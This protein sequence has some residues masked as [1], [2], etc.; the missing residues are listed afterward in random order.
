MQRRDVIAEAHAALA[1]RGNALRPP[2]ALVVDA[3]HP[4]EVAADQFAQARTELDAR[5]VVHVQFP[6]A[7]L[8]A[9][10]GRMAAGSLVFVMANTGQGKTT[11][12]LDVLDRWAEQD[13]RID[14]LGTEQEPNELIRKWACLRADVPAGVAIGHEWD[15]YDQ[16]ARWKVRVIQQVHEIEGKFGT[17]VMFCPDKFITLTKIELAA[18][19]AHERGAHVLIVDHVDRIEVEGRETEYTAMKKLV[20]RLKELARDHN[21]VMVVASQMN[22]EARKADRLGAYRAPQLHQMQGGGTKEQEADVV[23]GLW[24][25][26]RQPNPD[27]SATDFKQ[28]MSAAS[29]GHVAA[30]EVTEPNTMAVVLLKHRTHGERDGERCKLNVH[31]GR[32]S[33]IPE[34]DRYSTDYTSTRR[35]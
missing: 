23:I 24:R 12:L 33:E 31:H 27:E 8:H 14:Y 2:V 1:Q 10:V 28:L 9:M 34:K 11:F 20:R 6:Y 15:E 13:V 19:R 7:P 4:L 35:I 32:L 5:P 3:P 26:I 30:N 25:P 17:R 16:G 29:A 18:R 21:L 22:R